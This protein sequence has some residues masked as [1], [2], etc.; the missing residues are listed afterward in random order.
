MSAA[1]T[2]AD[3]LAQRILSF[4]DLC[5]KYWVDGCL[6]WSEFQ[7]LVGLTQV[8]KETSDSLVYRGTTDLS[9]IYTPEA[10]I[11][12]LMELRAEGQDSTVEQRAYWASQS[13]EELRI[14]YFRGILVNMK[15]EVEL[16]MLFNVPKEDIPQAYLSLC[17]QTISLIA[18][19]LQSIEM[20]GVDLASVQDDFSKI[21]KM[22]NDVRSGRQKAAES[23]AFWGALRAAA[24]V[25]K[26]AP[27]PGHVYLA[28]FA[29]NVIKVGVSRRPET[30]LKNVSTGSGRSIKEVWTAEF[31]SEKEARALEK[32]FLARFEGRRL[33]G[34]FLDMSFEHALSWL[35]GQSEVEFTQLT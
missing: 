7:Q 6:S 25:P 34:E 4:R 26:E 8:G 5:K 30:R 24:A 19:L 18:E 17:E 13:S 3:S 10:R 31:S 16:L 33:A 1:P 2:T 11:L 9:S 27:P 29:D 15:G 35:K 28:L 21:N 22:Y 32:K 12:W 14:H 23:M 20:C